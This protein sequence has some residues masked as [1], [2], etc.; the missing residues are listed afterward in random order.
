MI[1]G[2]DSDIVKVTIFAEHYTIKTLGSIQQIE[3]AAALVDATMKEI[4]KNLS[5]DSKQVA[6]LTALRIAYQLEAKQPNVG[7]DVLVNYIDSELSKL[8]LD[9]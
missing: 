6:V 8:G 3:S 2:S 4:A 7:A 1:P 5:L 9:S